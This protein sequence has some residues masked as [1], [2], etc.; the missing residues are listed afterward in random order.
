MTIATVS[1]VDTSLSRTTA[2]STTSMTGTCTENTTVITTNA[3]QRTASTQFMMVMITT[4]A[5]A[6]VMSRCPTVTTWT[7]SMTAAATLPTLITT[8]NTDRRTLI[9]EH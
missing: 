6:A 7:M 9:D 2:T 5:P 3:N 4:M 8:T 1:S